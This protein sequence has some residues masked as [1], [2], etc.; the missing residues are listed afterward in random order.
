MLPSDNGA[1][2]LNVKSTECCNDDLTIGQ[3][4][5]R[6]WTA[7]D[8]SSTVTLWNPC[9]RRRS[10]INSVLAMNCSIFINQ[11]I[12]PLT[13]WSQ[14]FNSYSLGGCREQKGEQ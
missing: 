8:C 7:F 12:N 1:G 3:L 2:W 13:L 4:C 11:R 6:K 10:K 9:K 14:N 5:H